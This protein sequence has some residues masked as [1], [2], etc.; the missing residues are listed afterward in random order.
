MRGQYTAARIGGASGGERLSAGERVNPASETETFAAVKLYIDNWRWKGVPFYLRSG[1]RMPKAGSEI[2][3][4]FKDAPGVLF[5]ANGQHL[6]D[7]V[8]VLR[9]QPKE[10]ISL[11]INAKTPG[12]VSADC[13]DAH[14]FQLRRRVS[15]ATRRRPTSG[16]CWMR[17][18]A[19]LRCSSATTRWRDRGASSIRSRKAGPARRSWRFIRGDVGAG[20]GERAV[21]GMMGM[22]GIR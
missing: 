19:S 6:T 15:A 20:G 11:L 7:N 12:T 14:G 5:A 9:V 2:C 1:K 16:C 22:R 10:G 4:H 3:I 13:A 8:L 18:W 21:G 17:F